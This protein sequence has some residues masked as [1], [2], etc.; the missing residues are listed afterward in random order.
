MYAWIIPKDMN[1]PYLSPIFARAVHSGDW[2][3]NERGWHEFCIAL[4][5]SKSN[6]IEI[7]TYSRDGV[8][9][10]V[11][12]DSDTSG[13]TPKNA[14]FGSMDFLNKYDLEKICEEIS[15]QDLEE[16]IKIDKKYGYQEIIK[17][18]AQKDIDD[19][20]SS[21]LSFHDA[22]IESIEAKNDEIH[23]VFDPYWNRKI[24]LWFKE[25]SKYENRLEEPEYHWWDGG[26]IFMN[27]G[28]I[29]LCDEINAHSL[30]EGYWGMYFAGK[31]LFYR[32]L[33]SDNN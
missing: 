15:S 16:C 14:Y 21:A 8:I 29:Y 23:V 27:Q 3:E 12:I 31:E 10:V 19:L 1:Q 17:I 13:W 28:Y 32:I 11:T 24:E 33:P 9:H 2:P 6:L 22:Y 5:N 4:D 30:D 26:S 20:M 18:K 25:K 7:D